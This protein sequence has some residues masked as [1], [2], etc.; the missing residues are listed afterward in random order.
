MS[1]TDLSF[2]I[3][4]FKTFV[5]ILTFKIYFVLSHLVSNDADISKFYLAMSQIAL[6]KILPMTQ[7]Q[8]LALV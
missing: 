5:K 3:Y 8:I 4:A 2:Y 6:S 1:R 7:T